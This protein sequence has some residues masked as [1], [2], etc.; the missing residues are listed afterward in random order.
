MTQK[1][2]PS[3]NGQR[4]KRAAGWDRKALIKNGKKKERRKQRPRQKTSDTP[5]NETEEL[6]FKK[7][8]GRA[9]KPT[10]P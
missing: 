2:A 6:G 9:Q 4:Q 7:C 3:K 10:K 5:P 1:S 8:S